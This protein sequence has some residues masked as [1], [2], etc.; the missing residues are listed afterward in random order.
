MLTTVNS[1]WWLDSSGDNVTV[2]I[3]IPISEDLFYCQLRLNSD[4]E[5]CPN[6]GWIMPNVW[7]EHSIHATT[8]QRMFKYLPFPQTAR[9]FTTMYR[10]NLM[11]IYG[12]NKVRKKVLRFLLLCALEKDCLAPFNASHECNFEGEK[13]SGWAGCHQ[14]DQSAVNILLQWANDFQSS[15]IVSDYNFGFQSLQKT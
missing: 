7:E 6:F 13:H 14:F 2:P 11:L 15:K 3:K 1:F 12:T 4:D 5:S 8:D 9:V 10:A